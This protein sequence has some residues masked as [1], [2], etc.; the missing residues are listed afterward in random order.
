MASKPEKRQLAFLL[1]NLKTGEYVMLI[2]QGM[3]K[4]SNYYNC[5]KV[6]FPGNDIEFTGTTKRA[7][8]QQAKEFTNIFW[9]WANTVIEK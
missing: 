5:G 8:D 2:D 7:S 3:K 9:S 4:S 1:I 6:A